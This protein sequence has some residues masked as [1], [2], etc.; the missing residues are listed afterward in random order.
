MNFDKIST[1]D[2]KK[3]MMNNRDDTEA[4]AAYTARLTSSNPE[5]D[6]L[7]NIE[8]TERNVTLS[9]SKIQSYREQLEGMPESLKAMDIIQQNGG[10]LKKAAEEILKNYIDPTGLM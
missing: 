2:L 4:F 7:N 8:Y 1:P 3:Y 6:E 9:P 10:D 5:L